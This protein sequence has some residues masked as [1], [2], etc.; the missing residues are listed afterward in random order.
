MGNWRS[1]SVT[2]FFL[3]PIP[4]HYQKMHCKLHCGCH[5]QLQAPYG[6][7]S[8]C[9]RLSTQATIQLSSLPL[10]IFSRMFTNLQHESE[11]SFNFV[12]LP[13]CHWQ[14]QQLKQGVALS[15]VV[16][17][18]VELRRVESSRVCVFLPARQDARLSSFCI[19]ALVIVVLVDIL[20]VPDS[21]C[22][23]PP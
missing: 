14:R 1:T 19:I 23:S 8:R 7:S 2:F 18:R 17:S 22:D 5:Q 20:V 15:P 10:A 9:L 3:L 11:F 21:A 13:V 6:P 12:A 16:T 4:W